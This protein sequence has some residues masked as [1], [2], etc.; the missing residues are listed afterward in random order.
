MCRT[1]MI[2]IEIHQCRMCRTLMIWQNVASNISDY[3]M[4]RILFQICHDGLLLVLITRGSAKFCPTPAVPSGLLCCPHADGVT[5][6]WIYEM[7]FQSLLDYWRIVSWLTQKT[8]KG[9]LDWNLVKSLCFFFCCASNLQYFTTFLT[10]WG[11]VTRQT[12]LLSHFDSSHLKWFS[13][14]DVLLLLGFFI[15]W[16]NISERW[17]CI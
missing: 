4:Q 5:G 6:G 16:W 12:N 2:C 10:H 9:C 13:C 8:I 1:L 3:L 7:I 15:I 11:I 14:F 17:W